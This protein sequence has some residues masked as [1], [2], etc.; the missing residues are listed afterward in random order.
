MFVD[1]LTFVSFSNSSI[2]EAVFDD[3]VSS[4]DSDEFGDE[5]EEEEEEEESSPWENY[6]DNNEEEEEE[7]EETPDNEEF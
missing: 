1:G 7:E 2:F 3:F 5:E 6:Y 4:A